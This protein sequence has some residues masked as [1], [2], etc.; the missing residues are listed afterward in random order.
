MLNV[1]RFIASYCSFKLKN[2]ELPKETMKELQAE[3]K[4]KLS[5]KVG[6]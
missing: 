6:K 5:T 4:R 3:I 1:L 2:E